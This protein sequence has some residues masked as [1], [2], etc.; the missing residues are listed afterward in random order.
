MAHAEKTKGERIA[1]WR[2]RGGDELGFQAG[3]VRERETVGT[4]QRA[5]VSTRLVTLEISNRSGRQSG[6]DSGGRSSRDRSVC[7]STKYMPDR[8]EPGGIKAGG[9]SM[10]H[11]VGPDGCF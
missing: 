11:V 1:G 3:P 10:L 7:A 9:I 4:N 8:T 2:R 5:Q 6:P